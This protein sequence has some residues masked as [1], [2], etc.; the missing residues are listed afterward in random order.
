MSFC[1]SPQ[2]PGTDDISSGTSRAGMFAENTAPI[3]A[4][5]ARVTEGEHTADVERQ[6]SASAAAE[7]ELREAR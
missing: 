2:S 3:A 1:R 5:D 4:K 7:Q 6:D